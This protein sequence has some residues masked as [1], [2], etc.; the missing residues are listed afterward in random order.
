MVTKVKTASATTQTSLPA[1]APSTTAP[2]ASSSSEKPAELVSTDNKPEA[3]PE[4]KS[5][6]TTESSSTTSGSSGSSETSTSSNL[7]TEAVSTLVTGSSYD[8]MVNEM[9]LLGYGREEVVAA[10]RVSFNNPDRAMEYL[11]SVC[12]VL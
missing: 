4:E 3:K 11:L 8:A 9:M 6:P 2:A 5:P 7:I 12:R 10:L 1:S